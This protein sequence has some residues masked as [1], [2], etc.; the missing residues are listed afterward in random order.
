MT[1]ATA[2]LNHML[3]FLG[4]AYGQ[5]LKLVALRDGA[6]AELG[7]KALASALIDGDTL[8][9]D[10]VFLPADAVGTIAS[11]ALY[12]GEAASVAVPGS[13]VLY[14]ELVLDVPA[15]KSAEDEITVSFELRVVSE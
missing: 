2:G 12:A 6:G 1:V 10:A 3:E 7:R 11:A 13:G 8:I 4:D 14:A 15:A 9:V 5:G